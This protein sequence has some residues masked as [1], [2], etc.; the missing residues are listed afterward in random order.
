MLLGTQR[1]RED[2]LLEIGGV[3]A[4]ELAERFG[5]PL[6]VIDEACVRERCRQYREAFVRA[7]PGQTAIAYASKACLTLAICRIVEQEGLHLDVASGGELHVARSAHFPAS[8]V[9]M[10]GNNKS[11]D[12]LAVA[13]DSGV[14]Y[15][16]VDCVEEIDR[17]EALFAAGHPRTR[18]LLRVT[19]GIEA[20]THEYVKTGRE[21]S[22]FGLGLWEGG[23]MEAVRRLL[24]SP[25][26][27]LIGFHCHIGSQLLTV[28]CFADAARLML[29]VCRQAR[30]ETGFAARILNLGGGL[31]VRHTEQEVAP[32]IEDLAQTI[33]GT[34]VEG[35]E[36]RGLDLPMV[37]VEPGRSIVGEAGTILYAVGVVKEIPG[38]RT[39]VAVDGG[40]SDNPRPALYGAEYQVLFANKMGAPAIQTVTVAGKH[41][42]TDNLF[43]DVPAPEVE[44]GDVIAVPACG[45][46][47]FAMSSN[48]NRLPR[49][50]VVH[51]V[52]GEAD[53][54]VERQTWEDLLAKER[55]PERL[56]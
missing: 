56:G 16:V 48:Y 35:C 29:D 49:P 45:A 14:G 10:H 13:M 20:H 53:V 8:R 47:T 23:A 25:A 46:Y 24:D 42:E 36:E 6:Y 7:Y 37:M 1:V 51:V 50:A 2:G 3:P 30:D 54:V 40:L 28:Q 39:Y 33:C 43:V 31:G 27:D 18:A 34:I 22:K 26:L 44:P 12:E 4:V 21:D 38:V 17:A 9:A 5:T 55:I 52:D 19:P 15:L 32:T 11:L 41:C